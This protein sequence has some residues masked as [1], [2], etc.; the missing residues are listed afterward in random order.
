MLQRNQMLTARA[1]DLKIS[2]R[3]RWPKPPPGDDE[4]AGAVFS[5]RIIAATSISIM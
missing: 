2:E 4:R 1:V 3:R 5:I